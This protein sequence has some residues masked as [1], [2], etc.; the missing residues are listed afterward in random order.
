MKKRYWRSLDE[1]SDTPEFQ[2]WLRAEFPE[3]ISENATELHRRDFLR[4]MG[5]SI[6]LAGFGA[7]TKQ[8]IEKIVPYVKQPKEIIPG[9]PLQFA[10]AT[11]FGGYA[12]GLIVTSHEGRPT[13][14][15]GNPDH[16]ASLG[17]TTIWAQADILDLYDPD[18]AQ[19]VT[20]GG[21]ISTWD[22]FLAQL[23]LVLVRQQALGGAGV[24]LLMK[25]TTSPTLS[26]Q[27]RALRQ[28]FPEFGLHQWDPVGRN[29]MNAAAATGANNGELNHDFSAAK[30]VV[31][32]DSDFL[33]AHPAALRHARAFASAR[34]VTG[35]TSARMNRLYVAEPTPTI[36][37]SNV[38]IVCQLLPEM[39]AN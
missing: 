19:S 26:T 34:R 14:I 10:T 22:N 3:G 37:G 9:K 33:Y 15:E 20:H 25:S 38:T 12:Q 6:A 7:C 17:A 18:R 27:L 13:K 35:A 4:L 28:K 8:P 29:G 16:P 5:A 11:T 32:L 31:A 30:V 23:N 39:Y 1:L 24:H 21:E 2:R 36:T